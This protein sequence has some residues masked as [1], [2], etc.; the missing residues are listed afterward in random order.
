MSDFGAKSL[1]ANS[2]F[3]KFLEIIEQDITDWKE[4]LLQVSPEGLPKL[5]GKIEGALYVSEYVTDIVERQAH[6]EQRKRD[7]TEKF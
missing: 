6:D 1:L 4:E 3:Q 5:Q 7:K 2:N